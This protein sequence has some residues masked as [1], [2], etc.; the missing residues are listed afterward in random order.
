[1][2]RFSRS[3]LFLSLAAGLVAGAVAQPRYERDERRDHYDYGHE[4]RVLQQDVARVTR[5]ER[6]ASREDSYLRQECW[7]ERTRSHEGDYYRD[8]A[9]RLY[10]G[11]RDD[12][13][14]RT[15]IGALI[16]GALGNQVGSGDGRRAATV[17]GA[18]VGGAIGNRSGDRDGYASSDGYM[19]YRDTA[20]GEIRC[21][22]VED[23]AMDRGGDLFRVSYTYGG[24]SYEGVTDTH[25]G[26]SL[27]VTVDVRP[28]DERFAGQR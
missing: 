19:H 16:G 10:R 15:V 13:T 20:G 4:D 11:G 23:V 14:A 1:M 17:A 27:R 5:V 6:I 2:N 9:G 21:R 24:R 28:R 7:N 3:I 12:R 26:R 18:V 8:D 22:T 25:P